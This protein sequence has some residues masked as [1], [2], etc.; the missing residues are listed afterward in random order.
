MVLILHR[1]RGQR[2]ARFVEQPLE[3]EQGGCRDDGCL[4]HAEVR[5]EGA[6]KH[7][8][9]NLDAWPI[10]RTL[11]GAPQSGVSVPTPCAVNYDAPP[12]ERVPRVLDLTSFAIVGSLLPVR[13]TPRE[14]TR[15]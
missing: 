3:L 14:R 7:P 12:T 2:S 4:R 5:A 10:W 11:G 6:I 8:V 9:G 13:T 1:V 15:G